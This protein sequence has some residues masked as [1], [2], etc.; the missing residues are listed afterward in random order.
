MAFFTDTKQKRIVGMAIKTLKI[1]P[2]ALACLYACVPIP[3]SSQGNLAPTIRFENV[4]YARKVGVVQ[5]YPASSS[6]N[7]APTLPVIGVGSQGIALQFD[8]LQETTQYLH[9]KYI[10]CDRNW[11]PQNISDLQ[12]LAEYNE[13]SIDEYEYSANTRIPY[14]HYQVV[15]PAPTRTGNYLIKVYQD[16]N[17]NDV[18]IT[19]RVLVTGQTAN[20]SVDLSMS[21]LVSRRDEGQQ[22]SVSVRYNQLSKDTNPVQ[23]FYIVMIQNHNWD[24]MIDGL[25]P[26][27]IRQDQQYLEYA[28][29]SGENVFN[30]L[31]EFRFA[32]LRSTEFRG[33]NVA[34]LSL[35]SDV[36]NASL[37]P[38]KPRKPLA[39]AQLNQDLN[40]GY[41]LQNLDPTERLLESEYI[42]THFE[43]LADRT[44][45]KVYI[46]G[47]FNDWQKNASNKMHY[48]E[49]T[50][51]YRCTMLLRQGYYDYI[52]WVE[53]SGT[54]LLEGNHYQTENIYEAILYYRN[55]TTGYDEIVGYRQLT[56]RP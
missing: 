16:N 50:G 10:S 9:A 34:N 51:S 8:L 4:N 46:L 44:G 37:I 20:L 36:I 30:G 31:N 54:A 6:N 17:E 3:P 25:Q 33:M 5:C 29:F 14:I 42:N 19:R 22:L 21:N 24:W 1:L 18:L 26:T 40:G 49:A 12:F 47:R 55:P 11:K 56:G 2:I 13:F 45:S 27:Q 32:D 35:Q 28:P 43:L 23:D 15:L 39:Y 7:Q 53:G 41:V 48:D 38:D 52:Y